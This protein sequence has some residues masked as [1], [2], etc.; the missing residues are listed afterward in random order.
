M[1][2]SLRWQ[3]PKPAQAKKK[4]KTEIPRFYRINALLQ[5]DSTQQILRARLMM[6]D[7]SEVGVGIFLPEM[8]TIGERVTLAIDRPTSLFLKG[9]VVR[10]GLYVLKTRVLSLENFTYRSYMRLRFDTEEERE[11]LRHYLLSA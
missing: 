3:L 9:D 6:S 11:A 4:E 2:E 10:S 7:L 1:F 8:V 5:R